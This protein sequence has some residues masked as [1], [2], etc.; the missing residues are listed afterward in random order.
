[1]KSAIYA[2]LSKDDGSQ[3]N[4]NQLLELRQFAASQN[5]VLYKEFLDQES[6]AK[7]DREQFQAMLRD[8]SRRKFDVLLVWNSDR[9][10]REGPY[11]TLHCLKMLDGYGVRFRSYTESFL[12]TTGPVRDLLIAIAGW[13]AQQEREKIRIRT[14][15]GQARARAQG[16]H[17]GRPKVVVDV[18][19][20][21]A[22]RSEGLSWSEIKNETGVTKGTAQRALARLPK[23]VSQRGD[24]SVAESAAKVETAAR[25]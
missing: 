6:G 19:R 14:L 2:R 13:L 8:A 22:L 7:G 12:D 9:L 24:I 21:A 20:L 25:P 1:L 23:S 11:E 4:E 10:T 17:I 5:W 18:C 16:K 15:A 3:T